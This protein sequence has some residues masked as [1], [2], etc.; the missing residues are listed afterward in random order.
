MMGM[1][2]YIMY[3]KIYTVYIYIYIEMI[4]FDMY[5]LGLDPSNTFAKRILL[6]SFCTFTVLGRFGGPRYG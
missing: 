4:W 5:N 3:D 1:K 6:H 2:I